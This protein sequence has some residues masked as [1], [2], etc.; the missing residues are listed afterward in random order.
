MEGFGQEEGGGGRDE[1]RFGQ[2]EG[3][4]MSVDNSIFVSGLFC[5]VCGR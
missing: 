1:Q 4:G 2:E 3:G 5:N